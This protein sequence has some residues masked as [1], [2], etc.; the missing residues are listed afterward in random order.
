[1][2]NGY[3]K[4]E[5]LVKKLQILK[6]YLVSVAQDGELTDYWVTMENT[7]IFTARQS[8]V[9]GFLGLH[10]D[11]L[12]NPLLPSIVVSTNSDMPGNKYF[13]MVQATQNYTNEIPETRIERRELWQNHVEEVREFWQEY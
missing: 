4:L 9:L 11:E 12:G 7:G 6:P 8:W 10:E 5:K 3:N 1:M 13:N 2:T